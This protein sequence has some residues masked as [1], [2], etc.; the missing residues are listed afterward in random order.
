M[1]ENINEM[2]THFAQPGELT[3]I[4]LRPAKKAE[5]EVVDRVRVSTE[6]GLEGDHYQGKSGERHVTLIQAEHL[7]AT[8]SMLNK[9]KIDPK[10]TRRNL[11]IKGINILSFKESQ[12]KIGE[13]VERRVGHVPV[14][15][16]TV[17]R[18]CTI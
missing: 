13:K 2:K 1:A 12:F 9:D 3:W 17:K 11:V 10:L 14:C 6:S 5:C 8:A 7:D 4:G 15:Q 18:R 16:D